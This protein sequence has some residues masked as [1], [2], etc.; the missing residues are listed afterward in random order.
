MS[1]E[2]EHSSYHLVLL[3]G[4]D[5]T[6]KLFKPFIKQFSS[7]NQVTV[8]EY[9]MDRHIPIADMAEY[10]VPKLPKDK[11]LA[12]LGESYSGPIALS[13]AASNKLDIRQLILVA[14]FAKYPGSFLKTLSKW[15]PL[16]LL[17][18][19]P[20]PNF[21]IKYYCFAEATNEVLSN[22]LRESV[23]ANHPS[24]LAQRAYAGATIDVTEKLAHINVP[25]LYVAASNDR[26]VPV[27]A[28]EYLQAHLHTLEVTTIQ[29]AHFILQVQPKACFDVINSFILNEN[30]LAK[31]TINQ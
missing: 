9:P 10:I 20:I 12:I 27:T 17:L 6:G 18:R 25:C 2:G 26:M 13:L 3:P 19:L 23:R 11:P 7:P 24:V 21:I 1:Q 4:L 8:I 22:L 29:G 5:G 30:N 16:S 31:P 28:L 14:T 15:L